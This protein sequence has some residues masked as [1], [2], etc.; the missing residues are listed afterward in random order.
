MI[1]KQVHAACDIIIPAYQNGAVLQQAISSLFSQ[2]VPREWQTRLIITDDGSTDHTISAASQLQPP[3]SWSN[4][5]VVV[6]SHTGAAGA[7]NRGLEQSK[8]DIVLFL[9]ADIILRPGA[10]AVHLNFHRQYNKKE[11]AALGAVKWDSRLSPSPLMEWMMH[12]GTQNNFDAILGQQLIDPGHY[13]YGS[14]ISLKRSMLGANPFPVQYQS[15]GWEDLDLGR[16]LAARGLKL[17]FLPDAIGL[18][19]HSYSAE[20]IYHRQYSIGQNLVIYQQRHP[21]APLLPRSTLLNR[22][23]HRLLTISGVIALLCFIISKTHVKWSTPKLFELI[24]TAKLKQGIR[25]AMPPSSH[26]L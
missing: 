13:F 14:F 6:G 15:Y 17:H 1:N 19:H 21:K 26:S 8:A 20:N 18:H 23:K 25:R 9:G 22:V 5:V 24:L 11:H 12:G 16:R 2:T 7:R 10:L 3:A 4:T